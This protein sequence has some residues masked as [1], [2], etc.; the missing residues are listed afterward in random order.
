[1]DIL[2]NWKNGGNRMKKNL[3]NI[4]D[5]FLRWI[6]LTPELYA[7]QSREKDLEEYMFP[8]WDDLLNEAEKA[9]SASSLDNKT[10]D[11]ILTVMAFDN[12]NEDLLDYIISNGT[13]VFISRL[14]EAGIHHCQP[15]A[16]WQCAELI[17]QKKPHNYKEYLK[18]LMQ[19]SDNYVRQR[20]NNALSEG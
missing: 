10:I 15:Q 11:Q 9:I 3:S 16:R 17:R 13:D 7:K 18:E 19:D 8:Y 2:S 14:I 4:I 12:E 6:H 1:M 20:A 5:S